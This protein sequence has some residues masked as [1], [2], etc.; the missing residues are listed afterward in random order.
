MLMGILIEPPGS[1]AIHLDQ[2]DTA[3]TPHLLRLVH[4]QKR[5][6][7]EAHQASR[8]RPRIHFQT[9][10]NVLHGAY[11]PKLGGGGR[12]M[13]KEISSGSYNL[14]DCKF[15]EYNQRTNF[16]ILKNNSF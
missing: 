5:V 10:Q 4:G 2:R 7:D 1:C 12:D 14:E 8:Y 6:E 3:L 9:N 13:Q 15:P 11:F 16:F